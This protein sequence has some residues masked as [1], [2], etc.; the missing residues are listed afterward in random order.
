[1]DECDVLAANFV[2]WT[3]HIIVSRTGS[4][5]ARI[6]LRGLVLNGWLVSTWNCGSG[7]QSRGIHGRLPLGSDVCKV[8]GVQPHAHHDQEQ[9]DDQ[10]HEND[11]CPSF[12]FN[13]LHNSLRQ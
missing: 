12:I 13:R 1:M 4:R 9:N 3:V 11:H 5:T 10:G 6:K 2:V 7:S 8:P